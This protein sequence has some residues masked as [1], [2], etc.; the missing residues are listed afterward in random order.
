MIYIHNYGHGLCLYIIGTYPTIF[1]AFKYRLCINWK[2]RDVENAEN[3]Q[4]VLR[5]KSLLKT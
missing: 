5:R 4:G 1:G 2:L 3:R